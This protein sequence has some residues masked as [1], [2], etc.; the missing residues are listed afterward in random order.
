M[1]EPPNAFS[2]ELPPKDIVTKPAIDIEMY[3]MSQE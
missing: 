3:I 1:S 2:I